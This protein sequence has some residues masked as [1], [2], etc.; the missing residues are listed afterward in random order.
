MCVCA[1]YVCVLCVCALYVYVLGGGG[2]NCCTVKW[3]KHLNTNQTVAGYIENQSAYT[4]HTS[5]QKP[6]P[7]LLEVV[8]PWSRGGG[9]GVTQLGI[10]VY[11]F[12]CVCVCV[13]CVCVGRGGRLQLHDMG[14]VLGMGAQVHQGSHPD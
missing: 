7:D 3:I 1:L 10:T 14:G 5:T 4:Q 8:Q 6:G 13:C 12:T 9:W 2:Y 11:P